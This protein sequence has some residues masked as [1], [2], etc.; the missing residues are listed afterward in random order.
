MRDTVLVVDDDPN[1]RELVSV[2]LE[3]IGVRVL[4]AEDGQAALSLA[5]AASDSILLVLLDYSMP[6]TDPAA[7]VRALR[8]KL[9]L[10]VPIVL[11]T[12]SADTAQRASEL[13]L[14][15]TLSKPFNISTLEEL[16]LRIRHSR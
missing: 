5:E 3:P 1:L 2:V 9:D 13:G 12:A 4:A 14:E 16:V 6:M 15:L 10:S 11:C 8:T 7:C